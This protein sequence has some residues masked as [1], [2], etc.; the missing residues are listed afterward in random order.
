[1]QPVQLSLMPDPA[2]VPS[3]RVSPARVSPALVSPALVPPAATGGL[4]VEAVAVATAL[5]AGVIA[6]AA[7]PSGR[8]ATSGE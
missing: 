6:K 1:M 4:P 5:L 2:P 3:A 8:E 7:A